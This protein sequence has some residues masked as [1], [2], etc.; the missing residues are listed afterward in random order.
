MSE[1]ELLYIIDGSKTE[2]ESNKVTDAV[3]GALQKAGAKVDSEDPWGRKRLA[4]EIN[5]QDHGW[6]V[7]TRLS[8]E[9]AKVRELD[10]VLRLNQDLLRTVLLSADQVPTAEEAAKAEEDEARDDNKSAKTADKPKPVRK[11]VGTAEAKEAADKEEGTKQ[12]K[13]R[14]ESDEEKKARQVKLEE[15]LEKVSKEE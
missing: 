5:K 3:N 13:K 14:E 15:A 11:L 12:V 2:D 7:I 1:Y 4:Y 9:P 8:I 10:R 6:Y